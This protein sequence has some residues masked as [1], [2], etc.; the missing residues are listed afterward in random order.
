MEVLLKQALVLLAQQV[1]LDLTHG[2]S[3]Q[4]CHHKTL[5]GNFEVRQL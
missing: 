2:V 5:L 1:L 3:W 4:L